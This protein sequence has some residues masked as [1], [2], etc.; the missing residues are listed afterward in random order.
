M[1]IRKLAFISLI[2]IVAAFAWPWSKDGISR[3][4]LTW[5]KD[6]STT[7]KI[8]WDAQAQKGV[9]QK[10]YFDTVDHGRNYEEYSN[11]VSLTR[12]YKFKGMYNA[13]VHLENL[14]PETKY[15]FVI[16]SSQGVVS[17]R[18]WFE[19]ISD[20][21]DTK[22]SIISGGDSR[23]NRTPRVKGNKLVAKLRPHFVLFGGDMTSID[24]SSQWE[25]WFNDWQHTISADGRIT[26]IVAARGNHERSNESV[27]KLFGTS[28]GVFYALSFGGDLLRAYTLNSESSITG[29]QYEWLKTDLARNMNHT[30]KIAQYHRPM[31]PHVKKKSENDRIYHSWGKEFFKYGVD[32]V[33][34]SDSHTVKTTRPIAPSN[35]AGHDEGFVV[36]E[37]RG[38]V[39]IGEGCWGAPLRSN[40]DDKSWTVASGSF[41]QFKLIHLDSHQ[42]IA[43]TIKVDNA[44]QVAAL[45]DENR[46][47]L[48]A[49]LSVWNEGEVELS[50][51][52]YG[53]Q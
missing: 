31:R 3:I 39:Y 4:R 32:L 15:Y 22:L 42:L 26:P 24:I 2:T 16:R 47:D 51:R 35:S 20:R 49:N 7:M 52:V 53:R 1:L 48:P 9:S 29:D 18:Y 17:K 34:E 44:N 13:V 40:D 41:N 14:S 12:F 50:P 28:P 8:I 46:F 23:N 37:E 21:S 43:R 38:T 30:W 5:E 36:D 33:T 6:P 19:T 45:T 27:S 25:K 10:L 11:K